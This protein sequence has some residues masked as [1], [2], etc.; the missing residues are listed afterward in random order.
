M[1]PEMISGAQ[2]Y[3]AA[4]VYAFGTMLWETMSG[5][6]PYDGM[7]INEVRRST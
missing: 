7:L 4:D 3:A 2:V 6:K 1:A 5:E